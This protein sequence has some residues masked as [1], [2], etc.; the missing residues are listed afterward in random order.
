[1]LIS[2]AKLGRGAFTLLCV[3]LLFA[4]GLVAQEKT[5]DVRFAGFDSYVKEVMA[6]LHV[7]GLAVAVVKGDEIVFAKGYGFADVDGKRSVTSNTLFA[8]G[9]STKAFTATCLAILVDRDKLDWDKPVR[10]YLPAFRMYDEYATEHLTPRDLLS[11]RSGLPRHDLLWYGSSAKREEIFNKLRYLEPN[12]SFREDFEYQNLMFMTAGYLAGKLYGANWERMVREEIMGPLGMQRS[13]LSVEEMQKDDDFAFPYRWIDD[14]ESLEKMDFRNIDEVGPAGSINSSVEEMAQWVKLQLAE[15]KFGEEQLVQEATMRQLHTIVTAIRAYPTNDL[16]GTF[17]YG[18]GWFLEWYRGHYLVHHGG[19]IDGFSALVAF[20][21]HQDFG[22]VVLTN[23]NGNAA[24]VLVARNVYDRMLDLEPH[25][26]LGPV[27]DVLAKAKEAQEKTEDDKPDEGRVLGTSPSLPLEEYAG[28]YE[29][30]GYGQVIV[31]YEDGKLYG[32]YNDD[33]SPLVHYHF[34]QFVVSE[35]EDPSEGLRVFFDIGATGKVERLRATLEATIDPIV[36]MK[37][38]PEK[39]SSTE[40]LKQFEGVF[41]FP[42]QKAT[43]AV[44]SNGKLT[45]SVPPQPLYILEPTG[46]D[47]FKITGVPVDITIR[48]KRNETGEITEAVSIQPNGTFTMKKVE[49]EDE[50]EK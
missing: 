30:E 36:F 32:T 22:C 38:A 8:I 16:R 1:M 15:G 46:E 28:V 3:S 27:K 31:R 10:D 17:G 40:Y 21:P 14:E 45:L 2:K 26:W 19:N 6:E 29:N 44:N 25:D 23:L 34:D 39:F 50:A 13:V 5:E 4:S 9:S 18:M 7:P 49:Q 47:E 24:P 42:A 11:H 41:S 33:E 37:K 43:V 12:K 48:F 20:M 35:D